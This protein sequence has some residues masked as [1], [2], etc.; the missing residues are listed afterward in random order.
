MGAKVAVTVFYD[1][2]ERLKFGKAKL[3]NCSAEYA[4]RNFGLQPEEEEEDD[5]D[6]DEVGFLFV[7][8]KSVSA[9]PFIPSLILTG[10][11]TSLLVLLLKKHIMLSEIF[12]QSIT[13]TWQIN[14]GRIFILQNGNLGNPVF[15]VTCV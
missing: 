8:L 2:Y 15:C 13:K 7:F 12:H 5:D 1:N 9:T 10:N 6:E 3:M 11:E 4:K 14:R